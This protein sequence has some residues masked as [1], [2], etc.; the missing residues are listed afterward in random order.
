[1]LKNNNIS[2]IFFLLT[3]FILSLT[4]L[5]G[6]RHDYR[7]YLENWNVSNS[8]ISPWATELNGIPIRNSS[9]GPLHTL[10]GYMVLLNPLV[11]KILFSG[12]SLIIFLLMLQT[13]R[14][15]IGKIDNQNL[16]FILLIYPLFPFTI[17]IC[18]I[19]GI[20]DSIIALLIILACVMRGQEKMVATGSLIGL[21]A[22]LKFY[23]ILFLPF[24]S[25]SSKKGFSLKCFFSGVF[26]FFLGMLLSYFIW[27]TDI[28]QPFV[29]GSDREPKLLSIFKFFDF[30]NNNYNFYLFPNLIN[31]LILNNSIL[32]LIVVFFLFLHGYMAKI[33]WDY[34]SIIGILLLLISYKVGH[35]QFFIGWIMLLAWMLISSK[36][37]SEK[38]LFAWR[39]TPIAIYLCLFQIIYFISGV[40]DN[41]HLRNDWE[42]FR[43][44][45]SVPFIMIISICFYLNRSFFCKP[46][47]RKR[48]VIW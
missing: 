17:I 24:F 30:V 11:P 23:P 13:R 28:F 10:I 22:L 14:N 33:E 3:I 44:F 40:L 35:Q 45:G 6:E 7:F 27:G 9:Y 1:M 25:L 47:K 38:N 16:L 8:G 2:F 42:I 20:N 46:W 37:G 19:Y 31:I 26:I 48:I 15:L 12:S 18:Y 21:G 32:V 5:T 34:V 29:F 36:T 39:L 41:G 43:N 4:L